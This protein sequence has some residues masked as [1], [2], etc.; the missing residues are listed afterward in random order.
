MGLVSP[1]WL[2]FSCFGTDADSKQAAYQYCHYAYH[3]TVLEDVYQYNSQYNQCCCKYP[4]KC[5]LIHDRFPL[6]KNVPK[7]KC[8]HRESSGFFFQKL[9]TK[10]S[11]HEN[12]KKII[13]LWT[14]PST[15]N[16]LFLYPF[17]I[18]GGTCKN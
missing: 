6:S 4:V 9:K 12:D 11:R 13:T 8:L 2:R 14:E 1:K 16:T 10:L 15:E 5:A 7:N 18:F 17:N 3:R